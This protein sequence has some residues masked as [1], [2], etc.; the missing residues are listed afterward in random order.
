MTVY[1]PDHP[2][3]FSNIAGGLAVSGANIVDAKIFTMT[4]GMALDTFWVQDSRAEPIESA[5]RLARLEAHVEQAIA[6]R[7]RPMRE[8]EEMIRKQGEKRDSVFTVEPRVIID[9]TASATH[10]VVEVNGRD[11]PG[12]LYALTRALSGEDVQIG[13]AQIATYGE[14]AVDVFYIKDIFGLKITHEVKL[15]RIREAL[16]EALS[17]IAAVAGEAAGQEAAAPAAP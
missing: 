2:G 12:L 7:M 5:D 1:A 8:L 15:E 10:T 3:L 9:N 14:S 4:D 13:G 17:S 6:G 16:L 11:R